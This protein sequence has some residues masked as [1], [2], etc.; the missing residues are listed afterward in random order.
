MFN[1]MQM[2]FLNFLMKNWFVWNVIMFYFMLN[3][4]CER[5]LNFFPHK[6]TNISLHSTKIQFH[7]GLENWFPAIPR[8]P[9]LNFHPSNSSFEYSSSTASNSWRVWIC[10]QFIKLIIVP[11]IFARNLCINNS[12]LFVSEKTYL[13]GCCSDAK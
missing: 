6:H 13:L 5:K 10:F 7:Q 2:K 1:K 4:C 3:L 11:N 9:W 8:N 12:I